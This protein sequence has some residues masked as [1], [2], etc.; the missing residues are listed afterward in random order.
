MEVGQ[1]ARQL[2]HGQNPGA[3]FDDEEGQR[4]VRL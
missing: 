4:Q 3:A 1:E 2:S